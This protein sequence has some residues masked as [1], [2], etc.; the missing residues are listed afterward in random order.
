VCR[1]A[2]TSSVG[3]GT[4]A[5][6]SSMTSFG[7]KRVSPA[8]GMLKPLRKACVA[9]ALF[10]VLLATPFGAPLGC[11]ACVCEMPVAAAKAPASNKRMN[12]DLVMPMP[13]HGFCAPCRND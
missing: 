13:R 4:L 9:G 3:V 2:I 6:T 1:A 10:G 8:G 11:W 5:G 12:V 7:T